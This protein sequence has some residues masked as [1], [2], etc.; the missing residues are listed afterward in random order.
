MPILKSSAGTGGLTLG[1][2]KAGFQFSHLFEIEHHTCETLRNNH[3]SKGGLLHGEVR[4]EDV[5]E[6]NWDEFTEPIRL[7]AG[8][9]PCQP[10]SLAGRHLA[11][12]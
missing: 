8:G 3:S 10:F 7:L 6:L 5:S 9:A 1:L 4:A 12:K 2:Q 11:D